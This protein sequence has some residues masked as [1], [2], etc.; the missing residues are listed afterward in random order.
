MHQSK[1]DN[2][3]NLFVPICPLF[4]GFDTARVRMPDILPGSAPD[5]QYAYDWGVGMGLHQDWGG[6][7]LDYFVCVLATLLLPIKEREEFLVALNVPLATGE[8]REG[9]Q[10]WTFVEENLEEVMKRLSHVTF[11]LF[12]IS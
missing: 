2:L 6:P 7:L 3:S 1:E 10:R 5:Q 8:G 9:R 4:R 11:D 12:S